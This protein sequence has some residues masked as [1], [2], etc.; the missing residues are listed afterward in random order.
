LSERLVETAEKFTELVGLHARV[1]FKQGSALAIPFDS[2]RFDTVIMQHVAMQIS[3][4]EQLFAELTRVVKSGDCL[5]LHEIF[6]GEGELHYPL[7]WAT[8]RSMSALEP[9]AACCERLSRA[10]FHVGD[11]VDHTE[12]G[13]QYHAESIEGYDADL[14]RGEGAY[15]LSRD[16]AEA[17]RAASVAMERNLRTG[18]LKVG[19]L[20][21]RKRGSSPRP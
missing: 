15:G 13:R 7:A 21:T 3:E 2:E 8:E 11:F 14:A 10:G 4:K 16:V 20:V 6:A 1:R 5:A 18:S 12:D 9:L 19:M 17:R